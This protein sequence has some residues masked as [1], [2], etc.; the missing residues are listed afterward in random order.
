MKRTKKASR[1]PIKRRGYDV[2]AVE[3]YIAAEI[4]RAEGAQLSARERISSL[5]AEREELKRQL[6]EL[7]GKE[8][9]IK[10]AVISATQN[11]DRLTA[12]AKARYALELNRL[13]LFR[14][15]WTGAYEEL[16]ERYHFDKDALN[17]ESVA[18]SVE[19]DL[20]KMLSQDFSLSGGGDEDEMEMYFKSEVARLTAR[21]AEEQDRS[22]GEDVPPQDSSELDELKDRIREAEA[23]T[24]TSA[25]FSLDEALHPTESLAEIC[26]ALG[27]KAL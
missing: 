22:K 16:K 3:S 10:A 4:S 9:Q 18:V 24:D 21:Q 17:M 23:K 13:K 8:E 27:L 14:A 25:A 26:R 2:D 7:K 1:F 6:G 19:L 11:A 5:E 20:K 15:K 12:D